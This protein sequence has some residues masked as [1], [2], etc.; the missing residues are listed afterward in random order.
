M[1]NTIV[2]AIAIKLDADFAGITI[3]TE[4]IKQGFN[5][6]CFFIKMLPTSTEQV[7]G[8]RHFLKHQFD[9]HY[10]PSESGGNSEI[11]ETI[12]KLKDSL[13]I[14]T[15][16]SD[17]IRGTDIHFESIDGVL[18]SMVNYDFHVM[19]VVT[20]EESM[21]TITIESNTKG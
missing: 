11:F 5:E 13:E 7:V 3:Y 10:F 21:E 12:E 8:P 15:A 2:E 1:L 18:H 17:L 19:K 4:E 14:I 9:V 6:P 16:G 20:P